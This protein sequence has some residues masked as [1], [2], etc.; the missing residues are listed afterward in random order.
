MS[1]YKANTVVT[2]AQAKNQSFATQSRSPSISSVSVIVPLT[3][4]GDRYPAIAVTASFCLFMVLSLK[5]AFSDSMF[6]LAHLKSGY[7]FYL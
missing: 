4:K 3:P 6:S 7:A 2:I 5:C 1:H